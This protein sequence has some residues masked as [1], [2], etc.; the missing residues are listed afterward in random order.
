MSRESQKARKRANRCIKRQEEYLQNMIEK[1]VEPEQL[2]RRDMCGKLDLT[3]YYAIFNT[4]NPDR[5]RYG[6]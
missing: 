2:S 3:A 6:F 5:K 1:Y 4:M